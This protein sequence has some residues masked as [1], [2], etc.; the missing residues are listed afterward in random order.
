MQQEAGVAQDL[1]L[2]AG[3]GA[4]VAIARMQCLQV[5]PCLP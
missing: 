5:A 1:K 2:L 3:F 4:E